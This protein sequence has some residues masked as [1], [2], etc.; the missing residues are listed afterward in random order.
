MPP[1]AHVG[2]AVVV[3]VDAVVVVVLAQMPPAPHTPEQHSG[4]KVPETQPW[5]PS[6][7]QAT[8]IPVVVSHTDVTPQVPQLSVPP[9]PLGAVPQFCP[10]GHSVAGVQP[11]T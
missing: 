9:Q 4:P 2:G 1:L 6:G 7:M 10:A 3:V 8:H 5:S 11:Q